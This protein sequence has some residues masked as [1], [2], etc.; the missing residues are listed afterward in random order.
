MG[1]EA[2]AMVDGAQQP[3][4]PG[5]LVRIGCAGLTVDVAPEAGGRIAQIT[6][7]GVDWLVGPHD[8]TPAMIAWG[9]YPMVPWVGRIRA[10]RFALQ[11]RTYQLPLNLEGHAIHGVGFGM[12]WRLE[13][14]APTALE[15][16][17]VLPEDERWP[18]GGS[19]HQRIEVAEKRLSLWLSVTAGAQMMPAVIGWHPWFRKPE[20]IEFSP[21][22]AYPRDAEGMVMLPLVEPPAGPWDDCFLNDDPVI[23]HH[24]GQRLQLAS[25]CRHW[26]VYDQPA[27]ATCIEPES[28]PPDAFNIGGAAWLAPGATLGAWFT[29]EWC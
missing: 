21:S 4:P 27:H 22:L 6:Q 13:R 19:A 20:R 25:D 26:V 14:H 3:M 23:V 29:M 10:G 28:G 7:A 8:G 9:C 1:N 16:S 5:E 15:L 2:A 18:F 11:G 12:P 24:A 17:L